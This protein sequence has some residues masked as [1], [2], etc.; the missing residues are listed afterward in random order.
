MENGY[1]QLLSKYKGKTVLGVGAHP[2]D[3]ELGVGGTLARLSRAGAK[4][5]MAIVSVPSNLETRMEE[6]SR[7]AR[8]LG[9]EARFLVSDRCSRVEDLKNHQLVTLIDG[10]VDELEPA[11]VF[12]HCLANFHVDHRLVHDACLASQ[13]LNYFDLFCYSPTSCRLVNIAF[14]PQAYVDISETIEDKMS[15]IKTH[16]SQFECRGLKTEHFREMANQYG[17]LVGVSYAEG[18]EIVRMRLN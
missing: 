2:D 17:Q 13:R 1:S 3:L 12:S 5:V 11:A 6:A 8:I 18:L 10:L 9:G 4:V 16:A 15:A 14:K 7:A